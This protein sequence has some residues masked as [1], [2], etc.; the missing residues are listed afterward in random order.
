MRKINK[1]FSIAP[2]VIFSS[3]I[4]VCLTAGPVCAG[5]LEFDGVPVDITT[6]DKEDLVIVP[7]TGGH[8][9]IGTGTSDTNATTNNDLY[10]SGILESDGAFYAD[11]GVVSGSNVIPGTDASYDLG[12]SSKYW[13]NLYADNIYAGDLPKIKA[14]SYSW[15][16]AQGAASTVL[17]N[18]G[19]GTLTWAAGGAG[20]PVTDTQTIVKGSS[21]ATKLIRFE[22]DGLTTNWPC[23]NS[24]KADS[25]DESGRHGKNLGAGR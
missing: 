8:T 21:D 23:A 15:P 16:S 7:G 4:I 9:Q 13:R 17:T 12:S 19:S 11:G 14:I 22:V 1:L 2:A 3:Y 24:E 18:D 10:V 5:T 20:L 6:V 25:D